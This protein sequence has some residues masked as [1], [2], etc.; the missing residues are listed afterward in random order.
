MLP[1][2]LGLLPTPLITANPATPDVAPA[3]PAT[4]AQEAPDA[5]AEPKW[6]GSVSAGLSA[7]DGNTEVTNASADFNA[8]RK[9]E[10]DR[11]TVKGFWNY[12]EQQ[13]AAGDNEVTQRRLGA[14]VK[15]DYFMSKRTY[16]FANLGAE[17]DLKAGI[18][19]R[20]YV[21]GGAGYQFYDTE[22]F[23]LSGEAGVN[24]FNEDFRAGGSDDYFAAR[25]AETLGWQIRKDVKFDHSIEA[26]PSLEDADDFFG[27]MDN[28]VRLNLTEKMFAQAQWV[29]N[30]DN[31]PAASERVD[32]LYALTLGWSF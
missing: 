5:P 32:N 14:S 7:T 2:F 26:F 21:G 18:D 22:T 28:K 16:L 11:W 4:I 13:N 23:K 10:K 15:Y 27:R 31:T 19:L 3:A 29:M 30:Y 25:I 17:Y 9:G 12:A 1:L 6:T 24:L 8:E 20:T